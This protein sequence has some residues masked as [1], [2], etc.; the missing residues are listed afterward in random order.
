MRW[1]NPSAVMNFRKPSLDFPIDNEVSLWDKPDELRFIRNSSSFGKKSTAVRQ[2]NQKP[3]PDGL[4]ST[5]S[6]G[7]WISSLDGIRPT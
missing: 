1:L 6:S 5:L 3:E 4:W 2:A 7:E